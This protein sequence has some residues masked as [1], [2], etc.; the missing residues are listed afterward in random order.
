MCTHGFES[1]YL[2]K[3]C[4]QRDVGSILG[5]S[6]PRMVIFYLST[7]MSIPGKGHQTCRVVSKDGA[8]SDMH[9]LVRYCDVCSMINR[10]YHSNEASVIIVCSM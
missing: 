7:C 4:T 9:I 10:L 8:H 3:L 6:P 5:K 2:F 1:V